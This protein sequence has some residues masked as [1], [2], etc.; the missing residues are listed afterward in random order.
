[1]ALAKGKTLDQIL[2][3]LGHVAEGVSTAR[4]VA[5][6][7]KV[8]G[9]DM[10]IITEINRV[11]FEGLSPKTAVENLLGREQKAEH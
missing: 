2:A 4:E 9:I 5:R 6:K 1:M 7:A 11:L 8:L 10:P 3:D